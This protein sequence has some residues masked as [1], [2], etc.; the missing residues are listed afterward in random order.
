MKTKTNYLKRAIL[1]FALILAGSTIS[2]AQCDKTITLVSST[3]NYLNAKGE[4]ERSK[5]ETTMITIS[6]TE[7]TIVPGEEVMTGAVTNYVCNWTT[8]F[9]V[10]K[11][12]FNTILKD[13]GR[14]M[15]ATINLEGKDGKVTLTMTAAEMPGKMIQ[16]VADKFE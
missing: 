14:E 8:P 13:G 1:A 7:I 5:D 12:T 15:H 11:T 10:G 2:V 9:K 16:V 4:V 6:K 3:T